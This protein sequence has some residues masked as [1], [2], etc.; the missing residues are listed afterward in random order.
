[1]MMIFIDHGRIFRSGLRVGESVSEPVVVIGGRV[2]DWPLEVGESEAMEGLGLGL[3]RAGGGDYGWRLC[4]R[5]W[6]LG[7]FGYCVKH[8]VSV[9]LT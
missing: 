9:S 1:M 6:R 4:R 8:H 7:C 3:L 5:R 2:V